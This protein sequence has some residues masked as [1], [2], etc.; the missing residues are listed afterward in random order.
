MHYLCYHLFLKFLGPWENNMVATVTYVLSIFVG[1]LQL[2]QLYDLF[3][4][5][6][7]FLISNSV[8]V[9]PIND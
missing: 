5:S 1:I 8:F 7:E 3:Q 2:N 9:T 6:N 4:I